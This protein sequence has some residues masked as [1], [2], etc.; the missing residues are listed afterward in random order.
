MPASSAQQSERFAASTFTP[1]NGNVSMYQIGTQGQVSNNH[2]SGTKLTATEGAQNTFRPFPSK[3]AAGPTLE[4]PKFTS[5]RG[6]DFMAAFAAQAEKNAAKLEAENKAKRKADEF[7]SDED[8]EAEYERRVAEEDKAKRARIEAIAKAASGFTPVLSA[9]TSASP[10]AEQDRERTED[11]SC[12]KT[13]H[14]KDGQESQSEEHLDGEDDGEE[15][16]EDD[17]EDAGTDEDDDIQTAMAKSH[18]KPRNPFNSSSDPNSLFNRITKPNAVSDDKGSENDISSPLTQANKNSLVPAPPGTGLFGSRPSTPNHDTPT[19]FGGSVFGNTGS[20]TPIVDH[21]WNPASAIKFGGPISAPAFN[22]TPAT[23]LTKTN[24]NATQSPFSTFSA[25]ALTASKPDSG[26]NDDTPKAS[27]SPFGASSSSAAHS[28]LGSGDNTPKTFNSLFGDASKK[29]A[30]NQSSAAQVGFS[31]GG[32]NTQLGASPLLAPSNVS[33]AVTSRATSPGV[34]DN[35]SAAESGTDDQANDPQPN[36]MA[37]RPGEENEDVLL[38]VRTK[39]LEFMSDKELCAIGSKEEAGWKTRGVGPL[40]VLRHPETQRARIVM[41]SEPSANVVI[42]SPLFQQNSYDINPSGKEGASL[43]TG[44]YMNGKLKIWVLKFKSMK[45]A[46]ELSSC[47]QEN[48][49]Q[50]K[51]R[52]T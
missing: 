28:V 6:T 43:K 39:A 26:S 1:V 35:E 22:I 47:L 4:V 23:P 36:Y 3:P 33:S 7:D 27:T 19:P 14:S 5:A 32:P 52:E 34:T 25:A 20:S 48:A 2:D 11:A 41:R 50:G 17:Q 44:V 37:S 10:A 30:V 18:A 29:T 13:E 42:N 38:E 9:A 24:G 8:D 12:E 21:T 15:R 46:H 49:L 31:F 51:T 45:M 40:R 16:G